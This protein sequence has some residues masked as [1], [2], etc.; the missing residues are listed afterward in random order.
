MV[1]LHLES[2]AYHE[3]NEVGALL[4]NLADGDRSVPEI[5]GELRRR[6]EDP[7]DDLEMVVEDFFEDL[8]ERDLIS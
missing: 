3:L 6:V 7:P 5:A 8:R 1:L 2:G 4:W